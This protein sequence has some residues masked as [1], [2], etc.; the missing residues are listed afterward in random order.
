[1]GRGVELPDV[2]YWLTHRDER[3]R[4]QGT[5]I[6][7]AFTAR[8]LHGAD[9]VKGEPHG[10]IAGRVGGALHGKPQISVFMMVQPTALVHEG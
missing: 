8:S 2:G 7:F 3:S 1:M 6:G 9:D 10:S 4:A 5:R